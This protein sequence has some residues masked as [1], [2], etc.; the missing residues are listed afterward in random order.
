VCCCCDEGL[1]ELQLSELLIVLNS[2]PGGNALLYE[3]PVKKALAGGLQVTT[4]GGNTTD[5]AGNLVPHN[6]LRSPSK[7]THVVVHPPTIES[8]GRSVDTETMVSIPPP[9]PTPPPPPLSLS[10]FLVPPPPL[11]FL[12]D[13][14]FRNTGLTGQRNFGI[15][16]KTREPLLY[17]LKMRAQL[18]RQ[19]DRRLW[20]VSGFLRSA[21]Y[22]Q[23]YCHPLYFV[24]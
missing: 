21:Y 8:I 23:L 15:S 2:V 20:K 12:R 16:Q 4:T 3:D 9:P 10:F 17:P 6:N 11:I 5:S 18:A 24:M 13:M 7:D 14:L 19:Q 1:I 22:R